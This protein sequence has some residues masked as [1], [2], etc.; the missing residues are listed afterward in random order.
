MIVRKTPIEIERMHASGQ[1]VAR[2]LAALRDMVAPG[3]TTMDLEHVADRMIREAG[4][5]AAFKGYMVPHIKRRFPAT[6]CTS[7]NDEVVHGIPSRRCVLREGDIVKVDCGV[8]LDG[9]YG[10]SATTIPVGRVP[11][12]TERLLRVA[13]E[14]L[15]LGIQQAE[16]GRRLYDLSGAVQRHVEGNGMAVVREFAGHGIGRRLHEDPAVPNFVDRTARNV[17]LRVG[18]VLAIEPMVVTGR[19]K[20]RVL[21]DRFTIVTEDGSPAAHFEH[22]V[23]I[24]Q[25][26]P[27]LLT[28]I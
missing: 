9:Y 22:C 24:T 2:I 3:I 23:A 6:L 11:A 25:A 26:G 7:V 15:D 18:M 13:R 19:P 12:P 5:K 28:A 1:L 21:R 8:Q 4:A 27:R 20:T 10:D 17:R 14:A 16:V